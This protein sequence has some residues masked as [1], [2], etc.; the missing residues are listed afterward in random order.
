MP[1]HCRGENAVLICE[2]SA[3]KPQQKGKYFKAVLYVYSN[4][5]W[6]VITDLLREVPYNPWRDRLQT[7]THP[8]YSIA[9]QC[10]RHYRVASEWEQRILGEFWAWRHSGDVTFQT[11]SDFYIQLPSNG[12][13]Q[14]YPNNKS[15]SFKICLREPIRMG[16]DWRVGFTSISLPDTNGVL[17]KF[18]LNDEPLFTMKW[19]I[20][21]KK[22]GE[23][24]R[25]RLTFRVKQREQNF[26]SQ[27]LSVNFG[28]LDGVG[29]IK[30]VVNFFETPRLML[31][32]ANTDVLKRRRLLSNPDGTDSKNLSYMNF[33]WK[34][35]ELLIDNSE[36]FNQLD[37]ARKITFGIN[38]YLCHQMKW[39]LENDDGTYQLRPNLKM[40]INGA[41]IH[42]PDKYEDLQTSDRLAK[43]EY[44]FFSIAC[45]QKISI[46]PHGWSFSFNPP[47]PPTPLEF[48]FQ[49]VCG[50]PRPTPQDFPIFLA[51]FLSLYKFIPL[52]A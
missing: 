34:G 29:F 7:Q 37:P 1:R 2:S 21:K 38:K 40:E 18:T 46:S 50:G 11:M 25:E 45:F 8:I 15:N 22:L 47:P 19:F 33:V 6:S 16:S 12:S 30:T 42:D 35:D 14:E 39:I 26:T 49:R 36:T 17:P 41:K 48:P 28:G 44:Y 32:H 9:Q 13:K 10:G 23:A 52:Y 3:A 5:G 43:D 31:G 51:L 24:S 4:A 27:N 20:T